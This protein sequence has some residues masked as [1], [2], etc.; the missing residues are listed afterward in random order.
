MKPLKIFITAV[1]LLLLT[2]VGIGLALPGTWHAERTVELPAP[3][4]AVFPWVNSLDGWAA[5]TPW[6]QVDATVSGP[7]GGVG[8]TRSWD[9]PQWG[10]GEW[11]LTES[12]PPRRV[13]YEVRVEEGSLVTHGSVE[14]EAT[15]SGGTRLVWTEEGDFGWNP[16]LAYMALGM[17]RMQGSEMAKDLEHLL[18]L[19]ESGVSVH[20]APPFTTRGDT[21][22]ASPPDPGS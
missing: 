18:S 4:A 7:D 1:A 20:D 16:F 5:F 13:A 6:D 22:S 10:Q 11:V 15:G 14:L 3:P 17:N 21:A 12:E 8:A 2:L 9:D 19:V